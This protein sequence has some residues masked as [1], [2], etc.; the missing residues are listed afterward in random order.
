[1][2][3][4]WRYTYIL[5]NASSGK[6]Y[7]VENPFLE[8]LLEDMIHD[9]NKKYSKLME[10]N[11]QY[12]L[13]GQAHITGTFTDWEPRKMMLIDQFCATISKEME[14]MKDEETRQQYSNEIM[15]MFASILKESSPY[16]QNT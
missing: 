4:K 15:G 3:D 12:D 10:G 5:W 8:E 9:S 7:Q 13:G 14:A 16:G 2:C 11:P 6:E 1:M